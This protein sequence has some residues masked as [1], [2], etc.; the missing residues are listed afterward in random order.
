MSTMALVVSLLLGCQGRATAPTGPVAAI[1]PRSAGSATAPT[2]PPAAGRPRASVAGLTLVPGSTRKVEQLVGDLDLETK[3]PTLSR[4][5]ERFGIGGTDLGSSFEH[6]GKL[7]FLF[8]DTVSRSGG[9]DAIGTTAAQ[10]GEGGV[11]LD[12]VTGADG[13]WLRVRPPGIA[14]DAVEVPLAGVSVGGEIF[15]M[16]KTNHTA[17]AFTDISKLVRFDERARRFEFV[18]D[19]SRLPAGHFVHLGLRHEAAPLAG[20][21]VEGPSVLMWGA[22]TYRQS[23]PYLAVTPAKT[24]ATGE[25]TRYFAGLDAAGEPTWAADEAR[26]A[27]LF[28]Q[29][30][31]DLSVTFVPQLELWL[32]LYDAWPGRGTDQRQRREA[33]GVQLRTSATPWG[34]WSAPEPVLR[35]VD[36]REGKL[37]HMANTDDGLEWPRVGAN[38]KSRKPEQGAP[39]APYLIERFTRVE[40]DRL[41]LYYVLSTWNPY[42]VVLMRS[43]FTVRR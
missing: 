31:G 27:P 11:R 26:A 36:A 28:E 3:R 43:E 25:G 42:V 23:S 17:G 13:K 33:A 12:F 8:G 2:L 16:V 30:V 6:E 5:E 18:R 4:T 20:L 15:L 7:Y 1:P 41:K 32:L 10:S 40:G 39:Y 38:G 9:G 29:A 24:W 34:P 35:L 19:V 37:V 21:P 14:M 22:G